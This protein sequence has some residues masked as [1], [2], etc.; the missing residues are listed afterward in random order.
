[1]LLT[2]ESQEG[3]TKVECD[4]AHCDPRTAHPHHVLTSSKAC[5]HWWS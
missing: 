3:R 5:L 1:M 4:V 2:G